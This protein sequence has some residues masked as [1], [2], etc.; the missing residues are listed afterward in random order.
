MAWTREEDAAL[1]HGLQT[2]GWGK[3]AKIHHTCTLFRRKRTVRSIKD[4]A[5]RLDLQKKY[6]I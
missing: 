4:R 1:R 3:W 5:L 6:D 2:F